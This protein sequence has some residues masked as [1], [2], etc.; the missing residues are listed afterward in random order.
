MPEFS[1]YE[2]WTLVIQWWD[3]VIGMSVLLVT[4]ISLR[5]MSDHLR[6]Q[7]EDLAPQPR[8]VP[9]T[10]YPTIH[11]TSGV[12]TLQQLTRGME[13]DAKRQGLAESLYAVGLE[14]FNHY[15]NNR[16][17]VIAESH[18]EM[19]SLAKQL[20]QQEVSQAECVEHSLAVARGEEQLAVAEAQFKQLPPQA[21]TYVR[22]KQREI[23]AQRRIDRDLEKNIPRTDYTSIRTRIASGDVSLD[24]ILSELPI[25]WQDI[26]NLNNKVERRRI[27]RKPPKREF[28]HLRLKTQRGLFEDER[29]EK[30]GDWIVSAKHDIMV[31]FPDPVPLD[32]QLAEDA[33]GVRVGE[34]V[35]ITYDPSSEWDTEFWRQHGRLDQLYLRTKNGLAPEQLRRAYRRRQIKRVGWIVAGSVLAVDIILVIVRFL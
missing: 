24:S 35:V 7:I 2:W 12:P 16:D 34:V 22:H 14:Q 28:L 32:H 15:V 23:D 5:I 19:E 20:S 21:Q 10:E 30:D 9:S 13:L 4:I 29:A 6:R 27:I 31:P 25:S 11:A 26:R 33:P 8:P 17:G 18:R 3:L 1:A